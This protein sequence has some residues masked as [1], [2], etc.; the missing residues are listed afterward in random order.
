MVAETRWC[1]AA[2]SIVEVISELTKV[3]VHAHRE[4][5]WQSSNP[6]PELCK[7]DES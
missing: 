1:V 7:L 3:R 6:L 4:S 5:H 2:H